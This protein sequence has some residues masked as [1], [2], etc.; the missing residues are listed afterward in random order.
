[1][2]DDTRIK[3]KVPVAVFLERIKKSKPEN[4][5]CTKHT[6]FRLSEK[7]RMIYESGKLKEII[8]KETPFLVGIQ[9]NEC[10]AIFY[11]HENKILKVIVVFATP[12]INIVT[13]YF[14]KEE[15]IPKI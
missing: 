12:K 4:I 7:Q 14:I 15:Q 9:Y 6:F 3:E 2:F 10:Y 8:L 13:F 1:M 11:R 5:E